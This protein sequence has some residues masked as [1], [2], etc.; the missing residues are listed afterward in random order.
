MRALAYFTAGQMDR[1]RGHDD[2]DQRAAAQSLMDLL[3]PVVKGWCTESAQSITATGVQV[4][5]GVG[6]IEET[7]A[8]QHQRDARITTIYEGTTGIQAND[9]I[10]R[11]LARDGGA[12]MRRLIDTMRD[13]AATLAH[14]GD[15]V[16]GDVAAALLSGLRGLAEATDWLLAAPARAASAGAVP[17][18]MMC[19]T[20][21]GGWLMARS[22]DVATTLLASGDVDVAY[23]AAKRITAH[24]YALHVLP[25]AGAL[26]DAVV[27]GAVTT[28]GLSDAQF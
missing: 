25:E 13:D 22:A 8:A 18:L 26:R 4:H 14:R 27:R 12:A 10:G 11:K 1:C 5:G 15:A 19:G 2:A 24:H 23:L 9:L 20:V 17:Y 21:I 3:I 7:G 16:L 6:F 28:L